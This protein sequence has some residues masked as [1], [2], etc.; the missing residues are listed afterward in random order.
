[1]VDQVPTFD[2]DP[3]AELYNEKTGHLSAKDIEFFQ[4]W[5]T[6]LTLEEQDIG[7]FRAQLWTMTAEKR[8]KTGRLVSPQ[9]P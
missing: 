9:T 7:R 1:M 6:L 3:I 2:D 5:E 4:K 8:E